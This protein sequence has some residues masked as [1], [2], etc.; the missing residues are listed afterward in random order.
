MLTR[1]MGGGISWFYV[2]DKDGNVKGAAHEDDRQAMDR[3][4]AIDIELK[5]DRKEQC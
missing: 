5:K 4:K 3:L 2:L 1:L